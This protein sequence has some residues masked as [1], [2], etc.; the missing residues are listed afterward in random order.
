MGAQDNKK[1]SVTGIF[2]GMAPKR[3]NDERGVRAGDVTI[4]VPGG[5]RN[6]TGRQLL[7]VH[8]TPANLCPGDRH[9]SPPD[10]S[11]ETLEFLQESLRSAQP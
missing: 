6:V 3:R 9:T 4:G 10:R 5:D 8:S 11:N 1:I 7:S 2:C